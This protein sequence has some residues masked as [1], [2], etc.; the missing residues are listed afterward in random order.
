M[1]PWKYTDDSYRDYTRAAW[2]ESAQKYTKLLRNLEPYGFDLL[3]RVDPKV[4]ERC[5]DIATGPGEPAMS[6]ARMVGLDGRVTGIDLSEHMVELAAEAAKR[7][8]IPNAEFGVMDADKMDFPD[9]TSDL[10]VRRFGFKIFPNPDR[11]ARE[12]LRF[13]APWSGI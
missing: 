2:N 10:A 11:V 9:G 13:V 5:L 3:A 12:P 7:R 4:R 1:T 8:R 6:I